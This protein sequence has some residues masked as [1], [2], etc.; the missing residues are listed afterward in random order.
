MLS[1]AV[2]LVG[3]EAGVSSQVGGHAIGVGLG[4]AT[5]VVGQVRHDQPAV[6]AGVDRH[7]DLHRLAVGGGLRRNELNLAVDRDLGVGIGN[8][9]VADHVADR[10]PVHLLELG[11]VGLGGRDVVRGDPAVALVDDH[12]IERGVGPERGDLP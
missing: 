7:D 9:V 12:R 6:L 3:G 11:D 8:A 4:D 1:N 10:A 2:G 5:H